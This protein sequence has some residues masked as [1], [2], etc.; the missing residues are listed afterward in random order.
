MDGKVLA[1]DKPA[2]VPGVD[3]NKVVE[4]VT[5]ASLTIKVGTEVSLRGV[6]VCRDVRSAGEVKTQADALQKAAVDFMKTAPPRRTA[7]GGA[8]PARQAQDRGERDPV[9]SDGQR[10]VRRRGRLH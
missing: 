10:Q 8:R 4:G 3:F 2:M 5:G 7:E 9:R 1:A 6:A